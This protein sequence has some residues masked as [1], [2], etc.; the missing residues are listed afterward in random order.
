MTERQPRMVENPLWCARCDGF[1][2]LVCDAEWEPYAIQC[3]D[4]KDRRPARAHEQEAN[5]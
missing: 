5:R 3:G 1:G 4:C 2:Y